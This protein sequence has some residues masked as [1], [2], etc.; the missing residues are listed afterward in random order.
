MGIFLKLIGGNKNLTRDSKMR[1]VELSKS[2]RLFN[3]IINGVMFSALN[4]F[5][6]A[7][8]IIPL[9]ESQMIPEFTLNDVIMTP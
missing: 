3:Y 2:P 4:K 6:N 5:S 7:I 1:L 9:L 8:L